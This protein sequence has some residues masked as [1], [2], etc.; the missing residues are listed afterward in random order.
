MTYGYN[1]TVFNTILPQLGE[2]KKRIYFSD[3]WP[4]LYWFQYLLRTLITDVDYAR[5]IEN[6][7]RLGLTEITRMRTTAAGHDS[8]HTNSWNPNTFYVF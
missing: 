5:K 7:P 2:N 6:N 3:T 1:I 8:A 4:L